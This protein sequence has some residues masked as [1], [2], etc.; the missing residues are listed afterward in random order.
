MPDTVKITIWYNVKTTM[1]Y[2]GKLI[3]EMLENELW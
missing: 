2:S 1:W 3:V